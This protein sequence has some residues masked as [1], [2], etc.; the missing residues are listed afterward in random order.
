M[1]LRRKKKKPNTE[2]F[3]FKSNA[4]QVYLLE[5]GFVIKY[6]QPVTGTLMI[7]NYELWIYLVTRLNQNIQQ[8]YFI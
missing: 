6:F 3:Q 5:N 8:I 4:N 2:T 1:F 7:M